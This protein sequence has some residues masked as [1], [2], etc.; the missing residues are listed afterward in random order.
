[1]VMCN[2]PE[3]LPDSL[4]TAFLIKIHMSSIHVCIRHRASARERVRCSNGPPTPL[5]WILESGFSDFGFFKGPSPPFLR[6]PGPLVW[7]FLVNDIVSGRLFS[8]IL[9]PTWAQL[10]SQLG[11]KI[12]P[13]SSQEGPRLQ[14]NLHH[15]FDALFERFWK[16]LGS[17]FGRFQAS[18]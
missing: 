8:K 7:F 15:G 11:D 6:G 13:K 5:V 3:K 4:S 12:E 2:H 9:M 14:A 18:S 10:A 16:H 1:M 17:S